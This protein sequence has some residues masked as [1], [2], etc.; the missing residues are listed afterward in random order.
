MKQF[1][2]FMFASLLGT[3]IA[4]GLGILFIF[5]II[6]VSVNSISKD[7]EVIIAKNSILHIKLSEPITD[8]SS[9]PDISDLDFTSLELKGHIGL[10]QITKS[11]RHAA[12]D[13]NIKGIYLDIQD[14][15][16]GI[17]TLTEI[18]NALLEFKKSRKFIVSYA[19]AYSQGAYYLASTADKIYV[20][21]AGGMDWRGIKA[22]IMFYK[23]ALDKLGIEP[24]VIRHGKFKSAVE[25]FLGDHMSDANRLQTK[26]FLSTIWNQ[27]KLEIGSSRK[28]SVDSLQVYADQLRIVEA[29][30]AVKYKLVDKLAYWDEVEQELKSLSKNTNKDL[31]VSLNKYSKSIKETGEFGSDRIAVIYAQ[32][33]IV[34]GQGAED[35]IGSARYIQAIR[36]ARTD[37][38]IKAVVLRVNS[39]GGSA[40][41]SEIM[42]RELS[43]LKAKK[44]LIISMG[45]LAASGGYYISC[46][47]DEVYAHPTTITG[48]IGVFG[49]MFNGKKLLE[50]KLGLRVDTVRTGVYADLGTMY[51]PMNEMEK[52]AIQR[53]VESIYTLFTNRVASGRNMNVADVDSIGQGRVWAGQDGLRLKLVD[54]IGG[55]DDAIKAAANKANLKNYKIKELPEVK[56]AWV[57]IMDKLENKAEAKILGSEK[58]KIARQ[59]KNIESIISQ[60]GIQARLPFVIDIE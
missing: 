6:S 3:F 39:P 49:L 34:D 21:P 9:D 16:A 27:L 33:N 12:N 2:K 52:A 19:E 32:G 15:S 31:L 60:K 11:L 56:S 1:F 25:P 14:V 18:R 10:N 40:L 42:W 59:I 13:A 41:A 23:N 57:Q 22:E 30:D 55:L 43:L 45:D 26:T 46:I 37:D 44:P 17:A 51:R 7:K 47:G 58:S 35:E 24:Q 53:G 28:I 36:K 48:S 5:L 8:R 54:K 4:I 50:E 29:Q 20:N 38:K